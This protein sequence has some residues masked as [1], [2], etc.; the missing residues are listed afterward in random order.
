MKAGKILSPSLDTDDL[1]KI[2]R[3]RVTQISTV[4]CFG[5]FISLFAA[6]DITFDI[7]LVALAAMFTAAI[8]AYKHFVVASSYLLLVALSSMLFALSATGAGTFDIAMLGYPAI[9]IFAA[10]LGGIGLFGTVLSL[11]LVQCIILTWL[12]ME[13]VIT[14]NTPKLTWSHLTFIMI[15]FVI[16]GFCVFI[17]VQDIR[18]LMTSLQLEYTKV[19]KNRE[20]I[21]YLAH[22]DPLTNLPNRLLGERLFNEKLAQ[23]EAN[24][25]QLALAFIDL[26]NFKPVN[27]ALGH[28]AGDRFL[29][30][31]SQLINEKLSDDECLIRFGGDE[32]IV[33]AA[34][35]TDRKHIETL[36]ERLIDWCSSE[37]EVFQ[38]NIVVSASI[39][40]AI[41]PKDGA[42]FKQ[43]CRKADVAMYE[44]KRNGR[45]RFEFYDVKFDEES[46]E[47]FSLIQRLRPAVLANQFEVYYQPL[48]DLK[49]GQICS[50]EALVRWPQEDGSLVFPDKFIPLAE[51]SGLINPLGEWVLIQ[52][53]LFCAKLHRNGHSEISVAVNL[54]FAQFKDGTLPSILKRALDLTQLNPKFLELEL[55]ESILADENGSIP[56][57]LE[58]MKNLGVQFA[59]DD[60]GTGYSNLN[61]LRKFNA[62]KLKIDRIFINTLGLDEND[63]PLVSA[64]INIAESLG[65]V[66][67]AEGIEHEAALKKL[68]EMGCDVGQGFYWSKPVPEKQIEALI[69]SQSYTL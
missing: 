64:I 34:N 36:C 49:S 52:A 24:G 12:V 44:A 2:R 69:A 1:I 23:S 27:D 19:K 55:T 8:L 16:T 4:T 26:D 21:Q 7:M 62:H 60:F 53:C 25:L 42:K 47:K 3:H 37:F 35:I 9:I 41:A 61:Y 67:V 13:G 30:H 10:L 51:S 32:F 43:L 31:I 50:I 58:K 22:H 68:E 17:L 45:N 14:P 33:L 65:M 39:G 28:S 66:T 46:D 15:I 5:L 40:V 48:I 18:R 38:T 56:E 57:Q 63:V 20:H 29:Q 11:V 59:I 6:R 54:S